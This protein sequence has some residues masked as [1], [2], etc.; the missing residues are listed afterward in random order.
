MPTAPPPTRRPI[1]IAALVVLAAGAIGLAWWL[2]QGDHAGGEVVLY[3]NVDLREVQ[4]AFNDSGRIAT[5]LA[6]EGD[7]LEKG[8]IIARL[9]T[10]RLEL[11][12]AE[13]EATAAG[14]AAAVDKL[15]AGNRPE[16]IAQAEANLASA[17]ADARNAR[18]VYDRLQA[19]WDSP[20][21]RTAV[22]QQTL[23]TAKST[24]DSA[25]AKVTLYQKAVE[26]ER[27]GSRK[28][29][30]AQGEA[31]LRSSEAQ[32][33]LLRRQL[34]D[35]ALA[36]P[37]DAVVR[38]RLMEPGEMATSQTPVFSLAVTDPKWVRTYVSEPQLGA[39]KPGMAVSITVDAFPG[40]GFP[41]KVGFISPV[42]EFT[43]TTVQTEEL[44][45]SLVYEVRVFVEDPNDDLRLGMPATVRLMPAASPAADDGSRPP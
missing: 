41:G 23:D 21:G 8:Q 28:E 1:V 34:E 3:G 22:T 12:V 38:S 4:V 45:T 42:A 39:V 15:H 16:E 40:R 30:I 20:S 43:P 32:L 35:A 6:E 5:V 26:L 7:R 19:L 33:A 37:T 10:S 27:A 11:Q 18:G 44:R 24:L 13:A 36:A 25:V 9:D 2:K 14:Q 17:E 29:D 31:Q